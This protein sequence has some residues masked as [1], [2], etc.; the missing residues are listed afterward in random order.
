LPGVQQYWEVRSD[1]YSD[2][3]QDFAEKLIAESPAVEP[4]YFSKEGCEE[5]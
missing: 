1:W 5:S 3:L 4:E 2:E